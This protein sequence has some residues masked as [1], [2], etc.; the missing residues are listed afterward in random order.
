M[1][2]LTEAEYNGRLGKIAEHNLQIMYR[3]NLKAERNKLRQKKI[4]TSKLLVFYLFVLFNAVLVYA[5]AAMWM[6]ADFSYLGV[7]ITDIAAQVLVY[8]TYC[9]KAYKAKQSEEAVKL[10]RDMA[11]MNADGKGVVIDD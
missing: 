7:L 11:G 6:F 1:K 10:E 9:L 5:M 8:A 4:E 3:K 2:Y